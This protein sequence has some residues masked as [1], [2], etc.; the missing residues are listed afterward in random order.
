M[1]LNFILRHSAT[2]NYHAISDS[3]TSTPFIN[4]IR[5]EGAIFGSDSGLF[6][7]HQTTGCVRWYH[8]M[9]TTLYIR[10]NKITRLLDDDNDLT[11]WRLDQVECIGEGKA[12]VILRCQGQ[13]YI[14]Q[15][16]RTI[17]YDLFQLSTTNLSLSLLLICLLQVNRRVT[18][19]TLRMPYRRR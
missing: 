17:S 1:L 8:S 19:F 13:E 15:R 11:G 6:I 3:I 16:T 10:T 9:I 18:Q 4:A 2:H 14:L 7:A 12:L 5:R